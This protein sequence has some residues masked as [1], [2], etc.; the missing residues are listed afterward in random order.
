MHFHHFQ[1]KIRSENF[2]SFAREPKESV[3]AC[4]VVA[5]PYNGDSTLMFQDG[6]LFPIGVAGGAN[7]E[8]LLVFCTESSSVVG[9]FV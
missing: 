8:C 3:D 2:S 4:G 5:G 9:D 7:D 6:I 1:I